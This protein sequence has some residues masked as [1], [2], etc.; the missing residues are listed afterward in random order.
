MGGEQ[1]PRM[2]LEYFGMI[3]ECQRSEMFMSSKCLGPAKPSKL[4][5]EVGLLLRRVKSE[6]LNE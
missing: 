2:S 4:S 1:E 3:L 6:G 5:Q